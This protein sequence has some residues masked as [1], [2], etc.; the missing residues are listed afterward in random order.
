V[1]TP[2]L[3]AQDATTL[4][5]LVGSRALSARSLVEATLARIGHVEPKTN[6]FRTV[7][8]S[9]ALAEAERIDSLSDSELSRLPLCGVPVAVKDDTDVAGQSTRWGSAT[10]RGPVEQDAEAVARLRRA[11]AVIIGK[12]NVPELTLWPWTMSDRWGVTT[13]PWDPSRT[14]GGSSGGSAAAVC[15]GMAAL[16]V[17]SDGGGSVRYPAGLTGLVGLKPQ[18]SRVPIGG[19]HGSAWHGLLALGSLSRSVRDASCFLDVVSAPEPSVEF[20]DALAAPVGPLRIGVSTNAPPGTG[21]TLSWERRS[22]IERT[23]ALLRQIGHDTVA[24]DIDYGLA[25]LWSST[26]R[27][28]KGVQHDVASLPRDRSLEPRTRTVARL[29]RVVPTRLLQRALEGEPD[30]A[31]S[32]NVVFDSV[33]VVLTP[34]CESPAPKLQD[35]PKRGAL[36]S[37]RAANTSAWLVPWNV[38]GQPALCVPVGLDADGLP[39]GVQLAGRAN[40][41]ATLLAVADQIEP[42]ASRTVWRPRS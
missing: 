30:I 28:L 21:V 20:R 25:A 1:T 27:L 16:A 10:D 22:W 34:L 15:S 9:E 2:D 18:R 37:L 24:V 42:R 4:A 26:V 5:G 41:E 29:G 11:G 3:T 13:N 14:P 31:R 6:A 38:I 35:C 7:M 12:T 8:A 40:D 19:E 33:D 39:V 17:G 36:R 32:I 23:V